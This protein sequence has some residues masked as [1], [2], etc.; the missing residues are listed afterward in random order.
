MG[1]V[2]KVCEEDDWESTKNEDL[3]FGS[4]ADRRDGFIHFSTSEQ[5][6]ETLEKY[7]KSKSP[8]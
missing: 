5:L 4:K 6:E 8:L 1:K 3:F 2:F 7:F